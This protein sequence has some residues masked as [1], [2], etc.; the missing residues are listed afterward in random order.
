MGQQ[1][2]K[3]KEKVDIKEAIVLTLFAVNS[4]GFGSQCPKERK[5]KKKKCTQG[6]QVV[7]SQKGNK[8][9]NASGKGPSSIAHRE[10]NKVT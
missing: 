2:K 10:K 7:I 6:V 3:E 8:G 5:L 1:K 9:K 4:T